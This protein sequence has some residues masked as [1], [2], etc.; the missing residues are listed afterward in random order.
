MPKQM[1]NAATIVAAQKHFI[2][3]CP[4]IKTLREKKQLNG[5]EGMV[6]K[7][8]AW[9]PLTTANALKSPQTEVLK[10]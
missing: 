4:L 6:S 10:A 5:Q 1:R 7:K 8:G 9:T 3:N 2:C